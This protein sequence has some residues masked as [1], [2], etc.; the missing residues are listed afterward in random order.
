MDIMEIIAEIVP[1]IG[2]IFLCFLIGNGLKAWDTFD[3]RKIP[4]LMGVS[5][6]VIG[7]II[8]FVEP[9]L[10]GSAGGIITAIIKGAASGWAAT[11][12]DQIGKQSK[13]GDME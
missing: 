13:K 3:D 5:G 10:L 11:G 9:D 7:V 6:A 8:Y 2:I 12:I 4:I 1:V